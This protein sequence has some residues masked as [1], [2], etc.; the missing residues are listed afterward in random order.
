MPSYKNPGVSGEF[1][2][3]KGCGLILVFTHIPSGRKARFIGSLTDY[4]DAFSSTWNSESVYGRMDPIPTFQR[5]GR[6]ISVS[7][8]ILNES[9]EIGRDN[10]REVSKLI[11]FL[12]PNY[13]DS[14]NATT[15]STAPLLRMEFA[16]LANDSKGQGLVG[17]LNGFTYD[18]NLDA[19]WVKSGKGELIAQ[20]LQ[21]SIQFTVLHTDELGWNLKDPRTKGFPYN[22]GMGVQNEP[23]AAAADN[24]NTFST[25]EDPKPGTALVPESSLTP[26]DRDK[27]RIT[28]KKGAAAAE[29]ENKN[30]EEIN[31]SAGE[32][33]L[34]GR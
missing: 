20:E 16:N 24:A 15:I 4:K 12:Y 2:F 17:Y 32:K 9:S 11:N 18:P 28:E 6:V 33:M 7:W 10:M 14:S 34:E 23:P 27:E 31:G 29:V 26:Q 22:Y 25:F 19:G 5:T 1:G 30:M 21:A 8:G 3:M 13:L